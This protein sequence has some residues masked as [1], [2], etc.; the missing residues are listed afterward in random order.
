MCEVR[1]QKRKRRY[2]MKTSQSLGIIGIALVFTLGNVAR[3]ADA[4]KAT[5]KSAL[6]SCLAGAKS[7]Y[8]L[9][10]GKCENIADATARKACQDQAK[11]DLQD[12]LGGCKDEADARNIG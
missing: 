2:T 4:C 10:L 6:K 5:T 3:G 1:M 9:A 7:D 12:A 8:A 11:V